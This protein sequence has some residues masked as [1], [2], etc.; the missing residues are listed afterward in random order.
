MS[1]HPDG[2]LLDDEA[3]AV[4][5]ETGTGVLGLDLTRQLAAEGSAPG[6]S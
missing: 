1:E 2:P 3:L 4:A 5:P 6:C